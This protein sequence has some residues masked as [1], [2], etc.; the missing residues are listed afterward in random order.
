MVEEITID[1]INVSIGSHEG[2][3]VIIGSDHRGFEYKTE[4]IKVFAENGYQ[5]ID[6]G[7]SSN[8]RCDYPAISDD[9]GRRVSEDPNGRVGIGICGSGIGILIPGGKH[10]GVYGARCLSVEEASSTRRHNNT[11]LLGI[12][13]DGMD[14]ETAI[15]T[16]YTW[17]TTPFCSDIEKERS[18][19]NRYVQTVKLEN[20]L[21]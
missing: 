1:G 5:V 15:D 16:V 13:A 19:L 11:N 9:I 3:T 4:V 17:M 8:E 2:K 18:Y 21:R 20:A 10:K 6:V 12:G 7:T 14:L